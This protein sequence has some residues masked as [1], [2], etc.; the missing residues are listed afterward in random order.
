MLATGLI[1]ATVKPVGT[2]IMS[3][4]ESREQM[5]ESVEET[6]SMVPSPFSWFFS[7]SVETRF[8]ASVIYQ[9]MFQAKRLMKTDS[10]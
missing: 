5:L 1:V 6:R 9:S 4:P 2:A 8:I 10:R 3:H 7:T